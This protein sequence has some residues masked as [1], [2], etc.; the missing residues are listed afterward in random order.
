MASHVP[1]PQTDSG[2]EFVAYW[3]E[4]VDEL[5]IDLSLLPQDYFRTIDFEVAQILVKRG[6]SISVVA[7]ALALHSP[8]VE[9]LGKSNH[10]CSIHW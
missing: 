1:K 8:S 3:A 9:A 6:H 5:P 10:C 2:E 4:I 7:E